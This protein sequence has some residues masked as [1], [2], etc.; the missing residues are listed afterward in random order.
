MN[1]AEKKRGR[2]KAA[3]REEGVKINIKYMK[4]TY[5]LSNPCFLFSTVVITCKSLKCTLSE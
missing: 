5:K 4:H 1:I 3:V 2:E